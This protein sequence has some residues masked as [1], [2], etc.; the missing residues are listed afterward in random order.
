MCR[1]RRNNIMIDETVKA[2][3]DKFNQEAKL[4]FEYS[5][6]MNK[7]RP[8]PFEE[9]NKSSINNQEQVSVEISIGN[10]KKIINWLTNKIWSK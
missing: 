1:L 2:L 10:I 7:E 4:D 6:L 9:L 8:K 5:M 3:Q